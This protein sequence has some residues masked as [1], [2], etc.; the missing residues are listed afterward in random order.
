MNSDEADRLHGNYRRARRAY[1]EAEAALGKVLT[2]IEAVAKAIRG[3]PNSPY[4]RMINPAFKPG[5]STWHEKLPPREVLLE[6]LAAFTN[7]RDALLAA[8]AAV[9][10]S[11]HVELQDLPPV[12]RGL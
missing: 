1:V 4:G 8:R 7:A 5:S 12:L 2:D 11:E 3:G 10:E 6:E 9:P